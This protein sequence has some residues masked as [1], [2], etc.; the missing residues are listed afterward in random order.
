MPP[1][2]RSS[3]RLTILVLGLCLPRVSEATIRPE[4]TEGNTAVVI[5]DM[6][7]ECRKLLDGAIVK[8]ANAL[9]YETVVTN[10]LKIIRHAIRHEWD[11]MLVEYKEIMRCGTVKCWGRT[12]ERLLDAVEGYDQL[13][14]FTKSADGLF[15]HTNRSRRTVLKHLRKK[16]ITTL[17]FLGANGNH[18]V[19]VSIEGAL[20]T[21]QFRVLAYSPGI[22]CFNEDPFIHP[23]DRYDFA[24]FGGLFKQIDCI[25]RL[26][27]DGH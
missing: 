13:A 11:I 14:T 27:P 7:S 4:A 17:L 12:D 10:Q 22:I 21:G 8:P 6:Q 19:R 2:E 26:P 23:Y 18:C 3:L 25:T 5:V 9:K 20:K 24:T 1:T 15:Y 16:R